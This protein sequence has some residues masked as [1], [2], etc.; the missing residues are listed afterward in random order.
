M[1]PAAVGVL[2]HRARGAVRE[3]AFA[4]QPASG[5]PGR[6]PLRGLLQ[7]EAEEKPRS[8]QQVEPA[9]AH[10]EARP[11]P[12]AERLPPAVRSLRPARICARSRPARQK[13][14]MAS[15]RAS[16]PVPGTQA[17]RPPTVRPTPPSTASRG[18][19][20]GSQ[21]RRTARGRSQVVFVVG[22]RLLA[23]LPPLAVLDVTTM[24]PTRMSAR[25][26]RGPQPT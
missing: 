6:I 21:S 5:S 23:R 13:V 4:E 2:E 3:G 15:G 18:P 1:V 9:E 22:P 26:T 25:A 17:K 8:E 7:E 20:C 14:T 24:E 19:R 11:G 12:G 10:G 16:K